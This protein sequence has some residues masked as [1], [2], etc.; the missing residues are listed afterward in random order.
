MPTGPP[1]RNKDSI[2]L[3][4][5]EVA[6]RGGLAVQAGKTPKQRAALARRAAAAR[7]AGHTKKP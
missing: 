5:Q 4:A 2:F 3:T 1:E 6:R 7:W